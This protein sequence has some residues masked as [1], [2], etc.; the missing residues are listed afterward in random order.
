MTTWLA[1]KFATYCHYL[2]D[3]HVVCRQAGYP[4]G[5]LEAV[6]HSKY[7]AAKDINLDEVDCTGNVDPSKGACSQIYLQLFPEM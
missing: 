2:Q 1:S 4:L 3:A 7:G 5:A 6:L